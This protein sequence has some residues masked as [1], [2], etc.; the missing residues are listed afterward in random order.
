MQRDV[1]EE[2]RVLLPEREQH[3]HQV[4]AELWPDLADHAEVEEV[5]R[6]LPPHEVAGVRVGVEEAVGEDLLVEG[7]EQ[8]PRGLRSRRHVGRA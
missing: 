3:E 6:V 8:L 1:G 5:D 4:L 2:R 7:L